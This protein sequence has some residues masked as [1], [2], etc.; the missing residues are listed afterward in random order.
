MHPPTQRSP[1]KQ[2]NET[3]RPEIPNIPP[4]T[5]I[6]NSQNR[7]PAPHPPQ[8]PAQASR[9]AYPPVRGVPWKCIAAIMR[10][11]K[12]CSECH[13]N[14][15]YDPPKLKFHQDVVFL[16]LAKHVFICRKDVTASAK[17]VD[18]FNNKFPKNKD[19]ARA[20]KPVSKRVSDESSSNQVS[21]R[22]F[23]SPSIS[24]SAIDSTVPPA[25]IANTVL[26]V[27]NRVAPT[28]TSNG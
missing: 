11:Y 2:R 19:Q 26:L 20:N 7:H 18:Q 8:P 1:V 14:H 13:F 6:D 17:V 23:H 16:A 15:S 4:S 21:A 5:T 9:V 25:P 3:T 27:P 28:P 22:Q 24:N 10:E 12:S